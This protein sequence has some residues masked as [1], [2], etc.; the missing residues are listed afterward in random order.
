MPAANLITAVLSGD[1]DDNL[2]GL[3]AAVRERISVQG[4]VK[5]HSFKVGE[6]V[7]LVGGPKYIQGALGTVTA[8]KQT[9]F[10]ID[11]DEPRGKFHRNVTCP[12]ELL[13]RVA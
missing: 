7:R 11:L 9:N 2:E 3:I 13:E 12:P 10:V 1:A 5:F 4:R 6:R 8:K